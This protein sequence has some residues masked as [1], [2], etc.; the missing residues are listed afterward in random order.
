MSKRIFIII[1]AFFSVFRLSHIQQNEISWDVLGYYLYLPAAFIHDDPLLSNIEWLKKLNEERNLTGTLYQLSSS[2]DGKPMYFFLPGMAITYLPS[3]LMAHG[4]AK[5]FGLDANGFSW[6]YQYLLCIG[7]LLYTFLGF[8]FFRKVLLNF[9]TETITSLVLITITIGT[10]YVHH[11]TLDNLATV[12]ILFLLTSLV[13]YHTIEWHKTQRN[14]HLIFLMVAV[15]FSAYVKPSEIFVG[16]IP[17]FWNVTSLNEFYKNLLHYLSRWKALTIGLSISFLFVFPLLFYWHSM[18]GQWFYDSYKNPG[19]GLDFHKPHIMNVLFSYRKGWF[20]YTPVMIF[21]LLGFYSLYNLHRKIFISCLAYFGISLYVISSWTEWWYGAAFSMRPLISTYPVLGI[22]L[23]F[24]LTNL[25]VKSWHIKL[26][27]II[28]FPLLILYNQFKWWQFRNY[29]LDPYRMTKEYFWSTFLSTQVT[30]EQK[31]LLLVERDFTGR[32]NFNNK[33]DY[34]WKSMGNLNFEEEFFNGKLRDTTTTGYYNMNEDNEFSPTYEYQY[35][36]L[37]SKDHV[38]L[39]VSVDVMYDTIANSF[40]LLVYSV[41]TREGIYE[42]KVVELKGDHGK[43][44]HFV[45]YFLT[46]EIRNQSDRVK[47]YIWNKNK[48]TFKIDNFEL[49]IYE[50]N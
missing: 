21:S 23:G 15:L 31:K 20:V 45:Q 10:N 30:P 33:E 41:E 12:N 40:P 14:N 42:Y 16:L 22:S 36:E 29:I 28:I 1:I 2:P 8:F 19:V 3:F 7:G 5:L 27:M 37:T 50:K 46:P 34:F 35:C 39:E 26:S 43:W 4:M 32:F 44:L 13:I 11:L 49:R 48:N 38:W 9:F 18:T 17:L 6:I 47:C 24:F 25:Y